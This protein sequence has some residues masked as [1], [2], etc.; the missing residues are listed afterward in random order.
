[1]TLLISKPVKIMLVAVEPSGDSL[2]AALYRE[3]KLSLPDDTQ[4]F[5]CGGPLMEVE[6]FKSAFPIDAFSVLGP[7]GVMKVIPEGLK[8]AKEIAELA[9]HEAM[10]MAIF[11]DGWTF[12]RAS[13]KRIRDLSPQTIIVKYAAPQI[14][15]SRPWR[16]KVVKDYFDAVLTLLPFEPPLFT[17]AGIRAT[18]VGNPNFQAV[19]EQETDPDGFR[20]K[21][22]IGDDKL[23]VVLPGSRKSEVSRLAIPF[24]ETIQQLKAEIDGL[25]IVIP[26]AP[27]VRELTDTLFSAHDKDV[28]FIP[29]E[30]RFCAFKAANAALAASG[31]VSTELAISDTPMIIAY[32]VDGLTAL[33]AKFLVN[34]KYIS[35][36]NVAADRAV[37]PEYLQ[38]D[39]TV[40]K[41][42]PAVRTLLQ[43]EQAARNQKE[44]FAPLIK[45]LGVYGAPAAK[46][47]AEE[48][49][50]LLV[51]FKK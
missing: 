32:K 30:E 22:Q 18:F 51:D 27:S 36:L 21:Y 5:G 34:T 25:R 24:G 23:L 17:Q 33:W 39:C 46:K 4:Y 10:D 41:L 9:E 29:P 20:A 8:R 13:S 35:I 38:N 19:A 44:T 45:E 15:A 37:I 11:I 3:L 1:M 26:A 49:L 7:T 28:I 2:G 16:V 6:G 14:W 40:E 42:V 31:T 12:S 48:I 43:D 47:A 50:Q